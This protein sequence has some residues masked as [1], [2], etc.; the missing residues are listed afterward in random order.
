MTSK[1][2]AKISVKRT[3]EL[4]REMLSTRRLICEDHDFFLASE[5]WELAGDGNNNVRIREYPVSVN[6][7]AGV[8]ALGE[9]ITLLISRDFAQR[10]KRGEGFANFILSHEY[11]HLLLGHHSR[12]AKVLNFELDAG[13]QIFRIVAPNDQELETNYA[14]V[15]LLCGVALLKSDVDE[16]D[17]AR[18]AHCDVQQVRKAIKAVALPEFKAAL[19]KLNQSRVR[20]VF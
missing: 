15:F 8:L 5:L 18:R 19:E 6:N 9:R 20:V 13:G 7:K 1:K 11:C 3:A 4:F 14:A 16:A 12:A 10:V 2:P 17:L